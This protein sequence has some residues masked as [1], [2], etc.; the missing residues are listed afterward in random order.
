M[1]RNDRGWKGM[2]RNEI[3]EGEMKWDKKKG[4]KNEMSEGK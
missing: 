1:K 2:K 4:R 3:K